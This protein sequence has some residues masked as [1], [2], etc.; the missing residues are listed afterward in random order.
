M[1]EDEILKQD[2]LT[3]STISWLRDLLQILIVSTDTK[4]SSQRE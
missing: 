4:S 2:K 3:E 1:Q